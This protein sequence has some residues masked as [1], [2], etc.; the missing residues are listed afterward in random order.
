M[1][2]IKEIELKPQIY[3]EIA[4]GETTL[5][6]SVVA[7][8]GGVSLFA[9]IDDEEQSLNSIGIYII[10]TDDPVLSEIP[11]HYIF[12]NTLQF[13]NGGELKVLHVYIEGINFDNLLGE[14][15]NF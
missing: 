7:R 6:L 14:Q 2:S 9:E 10:P 3:Q 4:T 1:R 11:E 13:I 15:G 5:V 12:F 8:P